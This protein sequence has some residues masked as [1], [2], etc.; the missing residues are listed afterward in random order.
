MS[1]AGLAAVPAASTAFSRRQAL[2]ARTGPAIPRLVKT[3]RPAPDAGGTHP[4]APPPRPADTDPAWL[5]AVGKRGPGVSKCLGQQSCPLARS[6]GPGPTQVAS[7]TPTPAALAWRPRNEGLVR[8]VGHRHDRRVKL[9]EL[10]PVG[11]QVAEQELGPSQSVA[12]ALFDDLTPGQRDELLRLLEKIAGSLRARGIDVPPRSGLP[13][14]ARQGPW[15]PGGLL[16]A[17]RSAKI[18][19]GSDPRQVTHGYR[20]GPARHRRGPGPG[21]P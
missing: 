6:H 18:H 16:S 20:R 15:G 10:T 9:V 17:N 7:F 3:A 4:G 13:P 5:A 2:L 1:W 11:R 19:T 8:R 14:P 12:A 21:S